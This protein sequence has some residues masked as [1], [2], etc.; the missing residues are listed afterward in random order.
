MS[1]SGKKEAVLLAGRETEDTVKWADLP[2][3]SG[4]HAVQMALLQQFIL[5][6]VAYHYIL[7]PEVKANL[8]HPHPVTDHL[9]DDKR[10]QAGLDLK[11]VDDYLESFLSW[12]LDISTPD[13]VG[14]AAF[15]PGL[16]EVNVFGV[17]EM[18]EQRVGEHVL[19]HM[20]W[21]LKKPGEFNERQIVGLF[22]NLEEHRKPNVRAIF[23]A[24][25]EP[26]Q[27]QQARGAG[28]LVRAIYEACKLS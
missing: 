12:L 19:N 21:R 20:A 3:A 26:V 7:Y 17:K 28:K 13:R 24:A 5:F 8:H 27:D 11:A 16:V 23:H 25:A 9:G 18:V 4:E 2:T 22:V 6:A 14:V 1:G 15:V 10:D